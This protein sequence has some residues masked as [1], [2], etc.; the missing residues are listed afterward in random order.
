MSVNLSEEL[1]GCR[2]YTCKRLLFYQ[3]FMDLKWLDER[4]A[5]DISPYEHSD[6]QFCLL[7]KKLFRKRQHK[8][9]HWVYL[10][11]PTN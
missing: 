11:E 1:R 7:Y 3:I 5:L 8:W 6:M 9:D 10:T 4:K 2:L